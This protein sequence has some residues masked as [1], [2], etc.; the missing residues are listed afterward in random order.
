[1]LHNTSLAHAPDP[2]SEFVPPILNVPVNNIRHK[3]FG[4]F[5]EA[6]DQIKHDIC[7]GEILE[8]YNLVQMYATSLSHRQN[9]RRRKLRAADC[10]PEMMPN[11]SRYRGF[12]NPW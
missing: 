6:M 12:L 9:Q 7:T 1:M 8:K 4:S 3:S 11:D 2:R 10:L 5:I